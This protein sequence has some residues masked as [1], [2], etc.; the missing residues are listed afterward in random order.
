MYFCPNNSCIYTM[1]IYFDFISVQ[2]LIYLVH[3]SRIFINVHAPVQHLLYTGL[4]WP[5]VIFRPFVTAIF[6][7]QTCLCFC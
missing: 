3:C 1:N 7:A 6:F 4:F 2:E 5:H